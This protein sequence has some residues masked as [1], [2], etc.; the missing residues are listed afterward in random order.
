METNDQNYQTFSQ[1][2][3]TTVTTY[4]VTTPQ[5]QYIVAEDIL[6]DQQFKQVCGL[7][8]INPYFAERMKAL[9][10]Y[11]IIIVAD[12]SGSMMSIINSFCPYGK[13][14]TRWDEL[15]ITVGIVVDIAATMDRNGV[16]VYFLNRPPIK[17][18]TNHSQLDATFSVKPNG[19]TCIVPILRSILHVKTDSPRLIIL[20]TDGQ[21][22]DNFGNINTHELKTVLQYERGP[23]DYMT[24]L[25]CTDEDDV[26][27]Y[28]NGWDRDLPRLDVV[29]DYY[30]ERKEIL[31]VQGNN[32][33]FSFGDYVVKML[34]GSVDKWFDGLDEEKVY[35]GTTTPSV[36]QSVHNQV[37][38]AE[39]SYTTTSHIQPHNR[40]YL[41]PHNKFHK[42]K[43]TNNCKCVIL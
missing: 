6:K 14:A 43:K 30:S 8:E 36:D 19:G 26:M 28:L 10:G 3:Q 33:V 39:S 1:T 4:D 9:E 23:N 35:I 38:V 20:A 42:Y 40:Y 37:P 7:Y 24:I 41:D 31:C 17:N 11:E 16:D 21:P 34:M 5:E 22:T 29:D 18:I 27:S 15:K 13:A 32:F 2:V 25:A 12:D